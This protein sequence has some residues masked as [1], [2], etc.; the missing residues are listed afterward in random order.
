MTSTAGG[1]L[2]GH[3]AHVRPGAESI[4]V[5]RS[6][7]RLAHPVARFGTPQPMLEVTAASDPNDED[8][9]VRVWPNHAPATVHMYRTLAPI[10]RR[11]AIR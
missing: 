8:L 6:H 2:R 11:V 9:A 10:R 3:V 7:E 5:G 1:A 4:T